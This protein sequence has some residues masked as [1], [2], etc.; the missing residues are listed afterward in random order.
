MNIYLFGKRNFANVMKIRTSKKK[1][2]KLGLRDE[3]IILDHLGGP[4]L[5]TRIF[6]G[7]KIS[8]L[9]LLIILHSVGN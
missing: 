6:K 4:N 7:E 8:L 1:K 2:R 3:Q 5:I 9:S